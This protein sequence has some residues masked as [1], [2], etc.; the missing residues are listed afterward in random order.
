M[1]SK[2]IIFA[3]KLFACLLCFVIFF[4]MIPAEAWAALPRLN[5]S[6]LPFL[7]LAYAIVKGLNSLR[8]FLLL[9]PQLADLK[10][11]SIFY[12][13]FVSAFAGS[14]MPLAV[15]GD[16][17]RF[18]WLDRHLTENNKSRLLSGMILERVLSGFTTVLLFV[19]LAAWMARDLPLDASVLA[20]KAPFL[21]VLALAV[22]ACAV[23][24]VRVLRK[25]AFI[26]EL[27]Q[28][29][30]SYS[31][32]PCHLLA[33]AFISAATLVFSSVFV[34]GGSIW[35]VG[36]HLPWDVI[37]FIVL[38]ASLLSL[39]PI[40]PGGLGFMEMT[41]AGMLIFFSCPEAQAAQI[42]ILLRCTA[43]LTSLPGGVL[44]FWAKKRNSVGEIKNQSK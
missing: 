41:Q 28:T 34:L 27:L 18:F 22:A 11:T 36:V 9:C 32:R 29:L 30:K 8:L 39:I 4:R 37:F 33:C 31:C 19:G 10:F 12:S 42:V 40:A 24:L 2:R 16:A 26:A 1:I 13:A 43:L 25:R 20:A 23:L 21:A 38:A 6:I 35:A 44:L 3:S 17:A 5:W 15:A 7:I 14:F